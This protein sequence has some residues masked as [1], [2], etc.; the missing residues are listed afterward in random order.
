MT[1]YR[2]CRWPLHIIHWPMFGEI[3]WKINNQTG[4]DINKSMGYTTWFNVHCE[5]GTHF[6]DRVNKIMQGLVYISRWVWSPAVEADFHGIYFYTLTG[7]CCV[8]YHWYTQRILRAV[9]TWKPA[10]PV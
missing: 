5:S 7:F 6:P 3:S 1:L 2:V 4:V 10:N 9:S 8:W